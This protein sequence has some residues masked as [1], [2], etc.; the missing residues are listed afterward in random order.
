MSG[1]QWLS[2]GSCFTCP[3]SFWF[4]RGSVFNDSFFLSFPYFIKTKL[5][6]NLS[7]IGVVISCLVLLASCGKSGG[8]KPATQV[9]A[10]VNGDE[11]SVHQINTA[12]ARSG[13]STPEQAKAAGAQ[14]L[15]R[16]VEQQL[17]IQKAIETKLDR[18]TNVVTAIENS[19]RQI[20]AQAYMERALANMPKPSVEEIKKYYVDHPQLFSQR[21]VFRFQEFVAAI[22]QDQVKLLQAQLDKT[23]NMNDVANWMRSQNIPFSGNFSI[24]AAEQ[25]PMDQ[26][27]RF[28]S[29][30]AGEY[31]LFPGPNR[32]LVTQ[33][34]AVQEAP[35]SEKEAAPFIER[36]L[37]NKLKAEMNADE[38]KKLRASA[39]VEYVGDYGKS[40]TAAAPVGKQAEGKADGKA[41]PAVKADGKELEKGAIDK[42]L[43]GL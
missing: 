33:L 2:L 20:L 10:K 43:S 34:V 19:R 30:K 7:R 37:V 17:M 15:E 3:N 39:K 13:A 5:H 24:K 18:D 41:Q 29:M 9:A 4:V 26:L 28:Q 25:L 16:L 35:L 21:R 12:L 6:M 8:D 36:F 23:K 27:P 22:G 1:S 32:I 31:A 11:I 38:I 42:G 40:G 14:I